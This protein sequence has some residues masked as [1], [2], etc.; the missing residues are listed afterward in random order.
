M[1]RKPKGM[2][3]GESAFCI[4]YLLFAFIAAF[5]FYSKERYYSAAMTLFLTGGDAFHLIPRII[6]NL[7]GP[8][9]RND[10]RLIIGNIVS[11]VTMTLFYV[12]LYQVMKYR[13][14]DI[15]M[16]KLIWLLL[17]V[18]S[19]IRI[20]MCLLP[21]NDWF[22]RNRHEN[23]WHIYRNIPFC[24]IGL[25]T[26]CYLIIY[27]KEYLIALLVLISFA[28]YMGTVLYV[29]KNPKM[30]MLMIPKT[31]CYIIMIAMLLK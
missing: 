5:I 7:I 3:Y 17:L 24:L 6:A 23:K 16:P 27:C 14:I 29:K 8:S 19:S 18:L 10:Q 28:C 13:H 26:I 20:I 31:V 25:L 15:E 11:S 22:K 30:G 1:N 2:R 9:K 4:L 12:F 21:Q